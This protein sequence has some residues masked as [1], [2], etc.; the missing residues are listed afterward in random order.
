MGMSKAM[1]QMPG[2]PGRAGQTRGEAGREAASD[3][4]CGPPHEHPG[5]G[6]ARPKVGAGTLLQAALTREN[7]KAA[8]KRVKA[9]KGAAG[10]DG[11]DIEHTAQLLRASWPQ[12]RQALLAGTYRPQP[13]RK[14]MIPK[15][16]GSQRELGISTVSSNCTFAQQRFGMGRD[17]APFPSSAGPPFQGAQAATRRWR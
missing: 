15:P 11:L 8:W 12:T 5:T 14:V 17:R 13:V 4:A 2:Q 1:R 7:L 3:E 16:D 6:S 10:V 9:N